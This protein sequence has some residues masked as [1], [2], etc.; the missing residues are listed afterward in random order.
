MILDR[1]LLRSLGVLLPLL[2]SCGTA[3][4]RYELEGSVVSVDIEGAQVSVNH[5]AI[6]GFMGAMTMSF[7]VS[8]RQMLPLIESGDRLTAVLVVE[9]RDYWLEDLVVTKPLASDPS[10]DGQEAAE[11]RLGTALPD[12]ALVN[13]DGEAIRISE[14][15]GKA[16]LL[17]FIYTRCP[18]ADFCPRMNVHFATIEQVLKTEPE[19][20]NQTH[21]LTVSF[22]PEFDTPARL[23]TFA[24]KQPSVTP[25]TLSHWDFATGTQD[26][27]R[28]ITSSL[29]LFYRQEDDQI[30]H[31]LRTVL[32]APDGTL[33]GLYRGNEWTPDEVVSD[34]RECFRSGFR[35]G[36]NR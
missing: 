36:K 7:P 2:A 4:E 6:P 28:E 17:T 14:F 23:K 18:L 34:L 29:G 32:I 21:L 12:V 5:K 26:N 30:V 27:L 24:L 16:V 19:L 8:Q 10:V 35:Q 1:S 25:E 11:S 15:V 33:A 31:N 3:P 20:Y 13:Q 9:D 22:D